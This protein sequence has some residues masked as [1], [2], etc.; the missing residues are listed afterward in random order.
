MNSILTT[1]LRQLL[2]VRM[3]RI[4]SNKKM[5][6]ESAYLTI[7]HPVRRRQTKEG[8]KEGIEPKHSTVWGGTPVWGG[9]LGLNP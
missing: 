9:A 2:I 3:N 1:L 5:F 6:G 4:L 7:K 8:P